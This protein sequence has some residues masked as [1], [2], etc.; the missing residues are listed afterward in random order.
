MKLFKKKHEIPENE[1]EQFYNIAPLL[2]CGADINIAFGERSNGKTFAFKE[3]AVKEYFATGAESAVIRRYTEDFRG[4]NGRTLFDD[5]VQNE[6]R[7]NLIEQY[8]GG[9]FNTVVF[10]SMAWY[11]ARYDEETGK[12]IKAPSPFC[13]AFSLASAEHYKSTSYPRIKHICFD[14]MITHDRYLDDEF[15]TFLS[16]LSTI[17]RN[18]G[19]VKVYMFGN[20]VNKFSCPYWAEFG[21]THIKGM[22]QDEIH[23]YDWGES[24]AK[25]AVEYTGSRGGKLSDK[26]F[27]FDNP[28]LRMITSGEWEFEAHPHC[29]V[30]FRKEHIIFNYFIEYDEEMLQCD[31]VRKDNNYFTFIHR[32]T[33]PIK[34][35]NADLIYSL[36]FDPRPNYKRN[37]TAPRTKAERRIYEFFARDKV[38]YQ[39]N[40]VGEIV[41]EYL[42]YCTA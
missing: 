13:T 27:A 36:R 26:F 41:A 7:G 28:R 14:E 19:D 37:I 5:L 17:I 16:I 6:T 33:T 20:T 34:D 22:K 29:P 42:K 30:K 31:V 32:K 11:M 25:I 23:L 39:D 9:K 15:V 40:E 21:L 35:E 4:R 24:R 2:E 8:S 1:T 10:E 12:P 18:R 38:F 3:I